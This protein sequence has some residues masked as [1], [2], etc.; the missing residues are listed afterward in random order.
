MRDL[1]KALNPCKQFESLAAHL[2]AI[3]AVELAAL[4]LSLAGNASL[5]GDD[6]VVK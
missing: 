1:I 5:H 6:D 2:A 4:S 3:M